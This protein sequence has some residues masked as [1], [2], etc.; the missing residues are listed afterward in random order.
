MVEL[1]G[2]VVFVILEGN[3]IVDGVLFLCY[4]LIDDYESVYLV[5]GFMRI[6][7]N[8][9]LRVWNVDLFII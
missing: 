7:Y 6:V 8:Y 5:F 1:I 4:V 3:I 2:M 9:V